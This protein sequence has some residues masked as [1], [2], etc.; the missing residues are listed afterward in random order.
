M[1]IQQSAIKNLEAEMQ[2]SIITFVLWKI[3]NTEKACLSRLNL[4]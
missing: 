1:D 2:F 4:T 3:A